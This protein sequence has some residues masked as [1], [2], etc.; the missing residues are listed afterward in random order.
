MHK[1]W[2]HFIRIHFLKLTDWKLFQLSHI[3]HYHILN[4]HELYLII[5]HKN[6]QRNK[7]NKENETIIKMLYNPLKYKVSF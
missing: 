1:N 7:K 3:K 6:K 2:I 4:N 5:V